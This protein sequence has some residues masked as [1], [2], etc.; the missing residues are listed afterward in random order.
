MAEA[1]SAECDWLTAE[2]TLEEADRAAG[3]DAGL[4]TRLEGMATMRRG[5]SGLR[6]ATAL[7]SGEEAKSVCEEGWSRVLPRALLEPERGVR[8]A[9]PASSEGALPSAEPLSV[10]L[11]APAAALLDELEDSFS[12]AAEPT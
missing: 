10:L 9:E 2:E 7:T 1:D 6:T 11:A 3:V 12:G 8:A 4:D 5:G